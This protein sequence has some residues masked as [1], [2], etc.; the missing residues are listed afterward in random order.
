[1]F[2]TTNVVKNKGPNSW[3]VRL[4]HKESGKYYW[5]DAYYDERYKDVNIDW[6]QYIFHLD[7]TDDCE[8][9]AFQENCDNFDEASSEVLAALQAEGYVKQEDN[10]DWIAVV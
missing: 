6:N 10:G 4:I 9:K 3:S 7:Y 8:R 2:E 5:L 1:M